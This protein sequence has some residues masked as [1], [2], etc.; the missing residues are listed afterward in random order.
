MRCIGC[1]YNGVC[2]KERVRK[3]EALDCFIAEAPL[4]EI[5]AAIKFIQYVPQDFITV[6]A[7]KTHAYITAAKE[8]SLYWKDMYDSPVKA[9]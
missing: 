4:R 5:Q 7:S 2:P 1:V 3:A 9:K 6:F 8:A